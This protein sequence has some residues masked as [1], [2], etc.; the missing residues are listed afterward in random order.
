MV[1]DSSLGVLAAVCLPLLVAGG[2]GGSSKGYCAPLDSHGSASGDQY[3]HVKKGDAHL[4]LTVTLV[5]AFAFVLLEFYMVNSSLGQFRMKRIAW[6]LLEQMVGIFI[7]ILLFVMVEVQMHELHFTHGQEVW[8]MLFLVVLWS[9]VIFGLA[10]SRRIHESDLMT[11]CHLGGHVLGFAG[12]FFIGHVQ[13]RFGDSDLG[14]Y[15]LCL[16]IGT[17]I[18]VAVSSTIGLLVFPRCG[19]EGHSMTV[20]KEEAHEVLQESVA[21]S[22]SGNFI[23]CIMFSITGCEPHL[24]GAISDHTVS[25]R[26]TLFCIAL[27]FLLLNP[28]INLMLREVRKPLR[29]SPNKADS[30]EDE[31]VDDY[32]SVIEEDLE[33]E[34]TLAGTCIGFT[35]YFFRM[36]CAWS[37]INWG[38]WELYESKFDDELLGRIVFSL[39]VSF[40][41]MAIVYG[42]VAVLE[43]LEEMHD[44]AEKHIK[45][46]CKVIGVVMGFAWEQT[47]DQA[48]ETTAPEIM[49]WQRWLIVIGLVLFTL[50]AFYMYIMPKVIRN[51]ETLRE[52]QEDL[53]REL[54]SHFGLRANRNSSREFENVEASEEVGQE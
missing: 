54:Q 53:E 3:V 26:V 18:Q 14:G 52:Y 6:R 17:L 46:M 36:S 29:H 2:G 35:K 43:H 40:S 23:R 9:F 10:F 8:M 28:P 32:D 39:G 1:I 50:P 42:S 12:F 5:G 34:E 27:A 30:E 48:I 51:P 16:L 25:E 22:S 41:G 21:F 31:S 11:I 47:F 33:E 13:I 38:R 24:K 4:A 37:V 20:Y 15:T 19:Q 49:P 44:T 7:A 45:R